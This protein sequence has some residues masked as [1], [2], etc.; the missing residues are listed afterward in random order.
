MTEPGQ[1]DPQQPTVAETQQEQPA[2][3]SAQVQALEQ[4]VARLEQHLPTTAV[5]QTPTPE[6]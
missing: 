1:Q 3:V 5:D 4:R 2:D 6:E